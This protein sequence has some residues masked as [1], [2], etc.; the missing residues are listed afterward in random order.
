MIKN[1]SKHFCVFNEK[2]TGAKIEILPLST[3]D[4]YHRCFLSVHEHHSTSDSNIYHR[5]WFIR[6]FLYSYINPIM[7]EI[8]VKVKG[9]TKDEQL[10]LPSPWSVIIMRWRNRIFRLSLIEAKSTPIFKLMEVQIIALLDVGSYAY[11]RQD[12]VLK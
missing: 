6:S 1:N 5:K 10:F 4:L 9:T 3:Y 7:E 8:T 11:L 12:S 2:W